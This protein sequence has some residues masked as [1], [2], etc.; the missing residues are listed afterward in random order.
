MDDELDPDKIDPLEEDEVVE[1]GDEE[2]PTE[3]SLEALEEEEDAEIPEDSY[4][5]KYEI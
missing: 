1:H 3:E 5:D 4:D 2:S